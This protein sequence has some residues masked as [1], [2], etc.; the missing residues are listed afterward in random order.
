MALNNLIL[1]SNG[2]PRL[3]LLRPDRVFLV[4]RARAVHSRTIGDRQLVA[5]DGRRLDDQMRIG[6]GQDRLQL[7]IVL[8]Q[9]GTKGHRVFPTSVARIFAPS[10]VVASKRFAEYE[11]DC[12]FSKSGI[13]C[14]G[15]DRTGLLAGRSA[16]AVFDQDAEYT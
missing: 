10:P 12:E 16:A 2:A 1:S 15:C 13:Q 4:T 9:V 11:R 5:A 7:I 6:S 8:E 14:L 3:D